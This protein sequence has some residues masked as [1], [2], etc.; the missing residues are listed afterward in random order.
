[1]RSRCLSEVRSHLTNTPCPKSD[2]QERKQFGGGGERS[3]L[4]NAPCPMPNTKAT[5]RKMQV[6]L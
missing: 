6:A 2:F 4:T 1:M 5:R 3:H